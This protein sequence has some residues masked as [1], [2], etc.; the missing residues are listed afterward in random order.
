MN[1][2]NNGNGQDNNAPVVSEHGLVPLSEQPVDIL[3][4]NADKQGRNISKMSDFMQLYAQK[5]VTALSN[6][7][8]AEIV[9][10]FPF[11]DMGIISD[12]IQQASV[13]AEGKTS[14]LPD[15][16]S[17]PREIRTKLNKGI[18]TVGPSRQTPDN[19][20]AV[21]LDENGVRVKDV[22][23]KKVINNP[24]SV[25][26]VRNITNQL[27]MKQISDK[28][29]AVLDIQSYQ[30][31]KDRD[32]QIYT[33]FFN[34]RDNIL[35]AQNASSKEDRDYHLRLAADYLT[36]TKNEVWRELD[37][38]A[39]H[40]AK[41]TKHPFFHRQA[42][43]KMLISHIAEDLRL[44]AIVCGLKMQVSEYLGQPQ[45]AHVEL[46]Q[47]QRDML[48]FLD[49]EVLGSGYTAIEL[50]HS[51][52][53]YNKNNLDFWYHFSQ[54]MEP[55]LK[56]SMKMIEAGDTYILALEDVKDEE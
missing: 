39:K 18:Y 49:V 51:N 11:A 46:Q 27:Q 30:L 48:D 17:L 7:P 4:T 28:L 52:F 20:R 53:E 43:I 55:K 44:S 40:L 54:E 1:D 23:L 5:Q 21:I 42:P 38:A 2:G 15:F 8:L 14:L 10:S 36:E 47:Y 41:C 19:L 29:S 9:T 22:T 16:D 13:L 26:T 33:P 12:V 6:S 32:H 31:D 25:Q 45:I 35:Y 24:G 34:A 50:V 3:I 37:T 56:E